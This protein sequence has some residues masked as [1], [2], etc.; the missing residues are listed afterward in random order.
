[1]ALHTGLNPV[2][3][4]PPLKNSFVL[5][6]DITKASCN[7]SL[8]ACGPSCSGKASCFLSPA[9]W[10]ILGGTCRCFSFCELA[11]SDASELGIYLHF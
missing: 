7:D 10:S 9:A 11:S 5:E 1:M 3:T 6:A 4:L 2:T 8:A